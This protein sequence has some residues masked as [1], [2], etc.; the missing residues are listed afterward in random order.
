MARC[1]I[2]DRSGLVMPM[3]PQHRLRT[4]DPQVRRLRQYQ[5]SSRGMRKGLDTCPP[6]PQ[7]QAEWR[8]SRSA[9]RPAGVDTCPIPALGWRAGLP[10]RA[11]SCEGA[12]PAAGH[13]ARTSSRPGSPSRSPKAWLRPQLRPTCFSVKDG[14][15]GP[16]EERFGSFANK[17]CATAPAIPPQPL[18]LL[19]PLGSLGFAAAVVFPYAFG[20]NSKYAADSGPEV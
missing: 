20:I 7:Q 19:L 3:Q 13:L 8:S 15:R 5:R 11:S 17:K 9:E 4:W 16:W 14:G 1:V 10:S 18:P 2:S 12:A 6:L